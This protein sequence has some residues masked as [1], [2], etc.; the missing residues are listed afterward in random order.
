MFRL[1]KMP[2]NFMIK[3]IFKQQQNQLLALEGK[4]IIKVF[5]IKNNKIEKTKH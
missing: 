3:S 2:N 1:H 5:K 4:K